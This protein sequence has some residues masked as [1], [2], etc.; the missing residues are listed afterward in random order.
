MKQIAE[1]SKGL[2][3]KFQLEVIKARLVS[4]LSFLNSELA[5]PNY[6]TLF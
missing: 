6:Y 4:N 1:N 3:F 5:N 2:A